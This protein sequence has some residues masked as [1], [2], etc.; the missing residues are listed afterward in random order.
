MISASAS[1]RNVFPLANMAH[2]RYGVAM[3]MLENAASIE[4]AICD[5]KLDAAAIAMG[6]Y[7]DDALL[8]NA[9][10]QYDEIQT[11]HHAFFWTQQLGKLVGNNY[12]FAF[13]AAKMAMDKVSGLSKDVVA[14]ATLV[15]M[16]CVGV[17][18]LA[19]QAT[20][21]DPN[22]ATLASGYISQVITLCATHLQHDAFRTT[23]YEALDEWNKI[24]FSQ[25]FPPE[26]R[27]DELMVLANWA[28]GCPHP[29]DE[30]RHFIDGHRK[31]TYI[32][33]NGVH[34]LPTLEEELAYKRSARSAPVLTLV[35][36]RDLKP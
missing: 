20:Y 21:Q 29:I 25:F 34:T 14:S 8:G 30:L 10:C 33:P 7:F 4:R 2:R 24:V 35:A 19:R 15:N 17:T 5:G 31:Y 23:F 18:A 12:V 22:I 28:D 11:D 36:G 32:L 13:F 3:G 6:Q 1:A 27:F 9:R 26:A 16:A